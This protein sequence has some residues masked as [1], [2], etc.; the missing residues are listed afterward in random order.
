MAAQPDP[1]EWIGRI[2][3]TRPILPSRS[4]MDTVTG[5]LSTACNGAWLRCEW[6]LTRHVLSGDSV[7][8]V[9]SAVVHIRP[10]H[11]RRTLPPGA[12]F[13]RGHTGGLLRIDPTLAQSGSDGSRFQRSVKSRAACRSALSVHRP[14][15]LL[16]RKS[17]LQNGL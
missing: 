10:T 8:P 17:D 7:S 3:I 6:R 15:R 2:E 9:F 14:V 5:A 12:C 4:Q 1:K 16:V 13:R 11:D